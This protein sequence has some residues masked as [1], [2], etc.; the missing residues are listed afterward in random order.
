MRN[1]CSRLICHV[2]RATALILSIVTMSVTAQE[3]PLIEAQSGVAYG[4]SL[5]LPTDVAVGTDGRVYVVDSGHHRIAY[6]DSAGN[7]LGHFGAEGKA[8][9]ELQ[10]PVGIAAGPDGDLYVADRGNQRLQVYTADGASS[11]TLALAEESGAVTPVDVVVTGDGKSLFVTANNSHRVLSLS[12]RNGRIST[13]WGG[14]GKDPGQFKYPASLALDANGN[15][16]V[17]D[18]LNQRIQVFAPDGTPGVGFGA[19]GAKP[20]TFLRPKGIAVGGNGQIFVS[21]SY[22]G[23]VQVFNAGGE[24]EGVLAT[25]GEPVRFEAPTGLAFAAGR[26]YVTDMLAGKVLT[27]DLGG[28]L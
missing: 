28:A 19:L 4:T 7:P 25:N 9:G 22:L 11:R 26:L 14:E 6:F 20:G 23:V 13:G 21:D 27:F 17:V 8:D 10:G 15:V 5:S 16:L 24:F 3:L 18:V 1:N 12:P 2:F